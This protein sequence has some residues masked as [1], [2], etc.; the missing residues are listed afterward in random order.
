[1]VKKAE[2]N[3]RAANDVST[4]VSR[5]ACAVYRERHIDAYRALWS[6]AP[7]VGRDPAYARDT[8]DHDNLLAKITFGEMRSSDVGDVLIYYRDHRCNHHVEIRSDRWADDIRLSDIEP[9]FVCTACG[10]RGADVRPDFG[11]AP[12]GTG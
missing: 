12:M 1:L 5:S 7:I 6:S 3:Q 9:G 4:F 2:I 10:K 8:D 11:R